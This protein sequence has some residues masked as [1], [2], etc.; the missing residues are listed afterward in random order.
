MNT[1]IRRWQWCIVAVMMLVLL[2]PASIV[3][4]SSQALP[5]GVDRIDADLVHPFTKGAGVKIAILDTGVDLDHPDF[6]IA[7]SI[8]LIPGIATADDDHGHGTLVAGIIAALDNGI[9]T[10]GVAPEAE[11][12]AVK[13][14]N[15]YGTGSLGVI[16]SGIEWAI[17]NHMNIINL[18]M[19][20]TMEWPVTVQD[21]LKK[22][23]DAGILVIAG[24]GN[25][26]TAEGTTNCIWAP[27]RYSPMLAV[28]A[29]DESDNRL[30]ESSTGDALELMAPGNNAY[31]T[32]RGGGYGTLNKTSA[33]AAYATGIAALMIAGGSISNSQVRQILKDTARDLGVTGRD[34]QYGY[35]LVNALNAVNVARNTTPKETTTATTAIQSTTTTAITPMQS[36]VTTGVTVVQNTANTD[37]IAPVTAIELNGIQG[38]PGFY[39]SEVQVTL[40]ARDNDGGSGVA[41]TEYSLDGGKTWNRY[42]NPFTIKEEGKT[43]GISD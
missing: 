33:A 7:G 6:R 2:M 1:T 4:A 3:F 37:I 13:V 8:S 42:D 43:Q 12:Y 36:T 15:E 20:S 23:Y 5:W 29:T 18:S 32:T 25:G 26:G 9:G 35:G 19:G 38:N 39:R 14:L 10:L 21:T 11:L 24:A 27:A 40:I 17:Q 30:A 22:A 16:Q 41:N 28:G 34:N 31:S